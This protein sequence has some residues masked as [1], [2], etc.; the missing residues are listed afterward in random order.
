LT[1]NVHLAAVDIC[2]RTRLHYLQA[3]RG[4]TIVLLHGGMGDCWSWRPQVSALAS[5]FRIIAYSRRYNFPNKNSIASHDYSCAMDAQDLSDFLDALG[6]ARAHMIGTSYGALTALHLAT[7]RAGAVASLMLVEPPVFGWLSLIKGGDEA[8]DAFLRQV[9]RPAATLFQQREPR[10]A[11]RLLYD[12]MRG[13]RRFDLL[14]DSE[15]SRILRNA[16]A[17]EKLVGSTNPFPELPWSAVRELTM[18]MLLVSGAQTVPLH[19][20]C[21][22]AAAQVLEHAREVIIPGAGHAPANENPLAFN[23]ALAAFLAEV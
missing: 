20:L 5:D 17:M 22:E 16:L 9:W 18:P 23:E 3:G 8:V 1:N 2:G 19:R 15:V 7:F 21:H 6:C 14:N 13:A 12:G 10:A 4:D 11:M